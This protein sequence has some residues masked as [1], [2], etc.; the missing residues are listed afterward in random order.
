MFENENSYAFWQMAKLFAAA[1]QEVPEVKYNF[2]LNPNHPLVK[3]ISSDKRGLN[4]WKRK[5]LRFLN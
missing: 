3:H 5:Q 1:G 4:V 2:E